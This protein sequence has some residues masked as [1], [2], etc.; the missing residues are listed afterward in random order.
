MV[1]ILEDIGG[2]ETPAPQRIR[3]IGG[4]CPMERMAL[5]ESFRR[6]L[7]AYTVTLNPAFPSLYLVPKLAEKGEALPPDAVWGEHELSHSARSLRESDFWF[8]LLVVTMMVALRLPLYAAPLNGL[9]A[10]VALAAYLVYF[11]SNLVWHIRALFLGY[12]T[13]A[14]S[15]GAASLLPVFS[16][17]LHTA[18]GTVAVHAVDGAFVLIAGHVLFYWQGVFMRRHFTADDPGAGGAGD[19]PIAHFL[20]QATAWFSLITAAL[21]LAFWLFT[22]TAQALSAVLARYSFF[23]FAG[24]TPFVFETALQAATALLLLAPVSALLLMDPALQASGLRVARGLGVAF[25]SLHALAVLDRVRILAI[26]ASGI[27]S[28]GRAQVAECVPLNGAQETDIVSLAAGLEQCSEHAYAEAIRAYARRMRAD[29]AAADDLLEHEG[30]GVSGLAGETQ[31]RLG[32]E[33]FLKA[34]DINTKDAHHAVYRISLSGQAPLLLAR[35]ETLLAVFALVEPLRGDVVKIV[36]ALEGLEITPALLAQSGR[37]YAETLAEQCGISTCIAE[38]TP[39]DLAAALRQYQRERVGGTAL[40]CVKP[41]HEKLRECVDAVIA[42]QTQD[43]A[44][45]AVYADAEVGDALGDMPA[46]FGLIRK[47]RATRHV[48]TLLILPLFA[49]ACAAAF[50]ALLPAIAAP[51]IPALSLYFVHLGALRVEG[52]QQTQTLEMGE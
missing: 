20:A 9:A 32:S 23:S 17:P 24:D 40:L 16:L 18:A 36:K 29:P 37:E 15:L 25:T 33:E 30:Q 31:C 6:A 49:L 28:R 39:E 44:I 43:D 52:K 13:P 26:R 38:K 51:L 46:L 10:A 19:A 48:L 42:V 11:P 41:Q 2:L 47:I 3:I 8:L 27:L 1:K 21:A 35:G 50:F 45:G 14:L 7:P 5:A 22:P 12:P 34:N 4:V